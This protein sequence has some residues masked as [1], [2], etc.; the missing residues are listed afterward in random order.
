MIEQ[1]FFFILLVIWRNCASY[2]SFD[3]KK[4]NKWLPLGF[5]PV[6]QLQFLNRFWILYPSLFFA[7]VGSTKF[8]KI[9]PTSKGSKR[10]QNEVFSSLSIII[11]SKKLI[12]PL[13]IFCGSIIKNEDL[14]NQSYRP[15]KK[16]VNQQNTW[17]IIFFL[18]C[19]SLG[20]VLFLTD[21]L[22]F[23]NN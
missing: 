17:N 5:W 20:Q 12:K 6:A 8:S 7:S 15:Q 3:G 2:K 21:W 22:R 11:P 9:W 14:L 18:Q 16:R 4:G 1:L 13:V 10:K 19:Y 23:Y